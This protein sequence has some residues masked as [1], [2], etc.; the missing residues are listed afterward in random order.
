MT[1]GAQNPVFRG[2]GENKSIQKIEADV[3]EDKP[4][5]KGKV[6]LSNKDRLWLELIMASP[7]FITL[8][9]LYTTHSFL[10]TLVAFHLTLVYGLCK[11]LKAKNVQVNWKALLKRDLQRNPR[12]LK[13]DIKIAFAPV[14]A[15]MTIYVWYRRT[16]PDFNYQAFRIPLLENPVIC[17]LLFLEFVFVNPIVEEV[18]WRVFCDLFTGQGKTLMNK[19][20]VAFHFGLYHW[21]VGYFLCQ[22]LLLSTASFFGVVALGYI[23]T[24]VKERFGLITA[25]VV[26]IGVD[27]AAV[28]TI[29]DLQSHVIPL[30]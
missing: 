26:H 17:F 16:F 3:K 29:W 13:T 19:L 30:Y 11:F 10:A 25:I 22:D 21:F 27:L 8:G 23:L 6:C 9:I 18:F 20:D 4:F 7:I 12:N 15:L 1:I 2:L 5:F 28:I 24:L 14:I